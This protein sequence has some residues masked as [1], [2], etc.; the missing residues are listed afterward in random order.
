MSARVNV[1]KDSCVE[2]RNEELFIRVPGS[3]VR[4]GIMC[5]L[6]EEAVDPV[7][8]MMDNDGKVRAGTAFLIVETRGDDQI[9]ECRDFITFP[10]GSMVATV[11]RPVGQSVIRRSSDER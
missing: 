6:P 11:G 8:N 9:Y 2:K 10:G 3:S 1:C 4:G 5:W 7:K